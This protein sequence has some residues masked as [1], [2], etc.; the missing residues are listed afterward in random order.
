MI[1]HEEAVI[2]D[3]RA[4]DERLAGAERHLRELL[5]ACRAFLRQDRHTPVDLDQVVTV[6][7]LTIAMVNADRFLLTGPLPGTAKA[8][9]NDG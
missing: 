8:A 9:A 3:M 4:L 7:K 2:D 6:G 5:E 1:A